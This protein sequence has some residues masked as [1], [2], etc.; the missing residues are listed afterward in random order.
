MQFTG[1]LIGPDG[2]PLGNVSGQFAVAARKGWSGWMRPDSGFS[3]PL[4]GPYT[5]VP[6]TGRAVEL[7]V[8]WVETVEGET[9]A[10]FDGIGPNP[11]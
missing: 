4:G 6:D 9:L 1:V 2:A 10:V 11:F 3:I 5:L 8:R 7:E